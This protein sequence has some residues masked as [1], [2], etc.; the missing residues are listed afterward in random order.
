MT[1]RFWTSVAFMAVTFI[2]SE[3][4]SSSAF[5]QSPEPSPI[6]PEVTDNQPALASADAATKWIVDRDLALEQQLNSL[7]QEFGA[8]RETL[9]TPKFPTIEVHGVFQVDSG[10]FNQSAN[11]IATLKSPNNPT[12]NIQDGA[13]FRRARLSANG[14]VAPN[15]NYFFQMDFA[16]PGRPTFTDVWFEVTK[17]PVLGNVRVGQWKQPFSLEVVSSFRY[18]TFAER[19]VLFNAFAPFRHIGVGFYDYAEDERMTWAASIYRSGQDQFGGSIADNGGYA[20][21]G[22]ITALPWWDE[23][24]KGSQYLHVGAGYNYVTPNNQSAQ[25]RTIPEYFI[26]SN[27][28]GT[29][30]TAGVA[31]PGNINGTPFFV[32]TSKINMDHYNLVGS[33]LLWVNGLFS[34]QSEAQ[35]LMGTRT[36]GQ[37]LYFPGLY[38]QA[39]YF[40]TGE[41]RP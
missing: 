8:F 16:F 38:A 18:T 7:R 19:S 11:N 3:W 40:L 2:V 32:D 9:A 4:L 12:G 1:R 14:S 34:L 39:G 31:T 35:W 10:W 15:M 33:E 27:G 41:H 37:R 25:F 28:P 24:S 36:N 29:V 22:R 5:G 6:T 30:G 17:V 20:G 21:V 13:D 26:G 23:E